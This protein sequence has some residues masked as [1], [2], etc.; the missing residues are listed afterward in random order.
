MLAITITKCEELTERTDKHKNFRVAGTV[1]DE[2][3]SVVVSPYCGEYEYEQYP[4]VLGEDDE[5]LQIAIG[6]YFAQHPL[7]D[8]GQIGR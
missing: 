7:L 2:P 6:E 8:I 5:P 3:F 1:A 4:Q